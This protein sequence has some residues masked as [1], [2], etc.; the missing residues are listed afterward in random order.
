MDAVV[1]NLLVEAVHFLRFPRNKGDQVIHCLVGEG[2]LL[3]HGMIW[4]KTLKM[5]SQHVKFLPC[6]AQIQLYLR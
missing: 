3:K 1:S 4:G 5:H 6:P 2:R